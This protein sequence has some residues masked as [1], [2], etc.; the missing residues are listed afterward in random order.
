M[1]LFL[2]LADKVIVHRKYYILLHQQPAGPLISKQRIDFYMGFPYT[3]HALHPEFIPWFPFSYRVHIYLYVQNR[4]APYK[5]C[6]STCLKSMR[7]RGREDINNIQKGI[8]ED[9]SMVGNQPLWNL[10]SAASW[11]ILSIRWWEIYDFQ[12]GWWSLKSDFWS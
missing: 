9:G 1:F 8:K 3:P 12:G 11:M 7:R 6:T 4:C 2:Y 5:N 10:R